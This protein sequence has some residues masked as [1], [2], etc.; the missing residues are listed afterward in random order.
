M[1]RKDLPSLSIHGTILTCNFREEIPYPQTS[2]LPTSHLLHVTF[3]VRP[4]KGYQKVTGLLYK[5]PGLRL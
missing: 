5:A 4:D 1:T 2:L 3:R